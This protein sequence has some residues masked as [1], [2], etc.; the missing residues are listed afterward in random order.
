MLVSILVVVNIVYILIE[1]LLF[2]RAMHIHTCTYFSGSGALMWHIEVSV[3]EM[4]A[5]S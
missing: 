2:Q 3:T 5:I 1:V 4:L